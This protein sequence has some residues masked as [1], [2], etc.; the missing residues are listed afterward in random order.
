MVVYLNG[1]GLEVDGVDLVYCVVVYL[2]GK[3]HNLPMEDALVVY[4]CVVV[5]LSGCVPPWERP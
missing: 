1:K 3:V 5:L 4:H 2:H